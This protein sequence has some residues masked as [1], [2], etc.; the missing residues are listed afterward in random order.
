[1]VR[2]HY[3]KEGRKQGRERE[4]GKDS[5]GW[6][7]VICFLSLVMGYHPLRMRRLTWRTKEAFLPPPRHK[8]EDSH[9][10]SGHRIK[11]VSALYL[12]HA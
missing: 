9:D 12:F 3:A 6:A 4:E 1:M 10:L 5:P 7:A 8:A 11:K 2:A